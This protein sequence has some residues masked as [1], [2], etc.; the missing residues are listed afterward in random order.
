MLKIIPIVIAGLFAIG[1]PAQSQTAEHETLGGADRH[2]TAEQDRGY[3]FGDWGGLRSRLDERG[4]DF[5]VQYISDSL[6]G[7]TSGPPS[8]FEIWNRVRATVDIDLGTLL[9]WDGMY[10][11]ATGLWQGGGNLGER[12]GLI[13]SPSGMS[14]EQTFRLDSWWLEKR[15]RNDQIVVRAGQFAGQ[16]FYGAQHDAASFIF[17]PMGYALDNLSNTFESFDPPS[18]PAA[19]IRVSPLRHIYV[20]SMVLAAESEPSRCR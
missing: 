18:T 1:R 9:H 19:E 15:W 7:S 16:D 13:S 8:Q 14:S 6:W 2:E 4:V 12:L 17:E 20:K 11:H 5:D 3:L 10:F